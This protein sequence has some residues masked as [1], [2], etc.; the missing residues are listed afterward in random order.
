MSLAFPRLF[1][2]PVLFG[3]FRVVTGI[4]NVLTMVVITAGV[5]AVSKRASET[6]ADVGHVRRSAIMLHV[7]AFGPVFLALLLGADLL[8]STFLRDSLLA[9]PLRIASLVVV[10]YAFY[11]VLVGLLNGTRRFG[12][13]AALDV[14]FSTLKTAF[15]ITAV[16]ATGSVAWAFGGFAAAALLVLILAVFLVPRALPDVPR[17]PGITMAPLARYLVPLAAYA[18]V[19]NLLLQ[20]DVIGLK[21]VLGRA[22]IDGAGADLASASAGI[23]GAAKNIALLPY[24]AVISLTLI[25][26]PLVSRAASCG[27]RHTAEAAVSGGMRLAAVLSFASVALLGSAPRQILT[28][29]FGDAYGIAAPVLVMLLVAGAFLA[30]MYVS[31]A[32]I[33]SG[34]R[35]VLAVLGGGVAVT[36]QIGMMAWLLPGREGLAAYQGAGWATLAGAA[37]GAGLV[38]ILVHRAFPGAR[39]PWTLAA[40]AG[41]AAA[42]LGI[43]AALP[44]TLHWTCRP[45]ASMVTFSAI[46]P[47]SRAIGREDLDRIR[48]IFLQG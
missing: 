31:I 9:P 48:R 39:W 1:G 32:I 16:V 20:A 25:V 4:L 2:D 13:Q 37:S 40:A 38:G 21:A 5:Q 19:L 34:G 44:S 3:R 29:L 27:D 10:A 15:M 12:T 36:V 26:F 6:G 35:P 42:S 46:L 8:A 7:L 14:T 17:E 18:L 41:C 30:L 47:L 45:L 28:L 24:Q 22:G 43:A 11:A 33:A 23:Y